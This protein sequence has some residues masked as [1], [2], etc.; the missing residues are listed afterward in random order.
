MVNKRKAILL[1]DES[2]VFLEKRSRLSLERSKI[3]GILLCMLEFFEG[4]MFTTTNRSIDMDLAFSSGIP[5]R[6]Q[7]DAMLCRHRFA[8]SHVEEHSELGVAAEGR[9]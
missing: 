1:I 8:L 6:T 7:S 3:V 5:I 2:D 4:V 9:E